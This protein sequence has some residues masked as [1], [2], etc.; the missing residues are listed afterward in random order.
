MQTYNATFT[1]AMARLLIVLAR[2]IMWTI[3]ADASLAR[4]ATLE[5]LTRGINEVDNFL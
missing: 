1:R 4:R 5:D 2:H 3:Y